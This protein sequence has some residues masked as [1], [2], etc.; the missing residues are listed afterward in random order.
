M[1]TP[2]VLKFGGATLGR[3]DRVRKTVGMVR[4]TTAPRVVVVSAREGVTDRLKK[5]LLLAEG[6]KQ[7]PTLN[8]VLAELHPGIP[9]VLQKNLSALT[10]DLR[11]AAAS[12]KVSPSQGDAVL[13]R[14]ER[15]SAHWYAARLTEVG[16]PAEALEADL[17]G[18]ETDGN[19]GGAIIRPLPARGPVRNAIRSVLRKGRVPVITGYI[20]RGTRGKV[21]TL[22]RG[23]SDYTATS[24][25]CLIGARRT[26]LVKTDVSLFTADPKL[27]RR[28]EPVR[29]LSYEEAEE[30][31]QF[32]AKVL[33]PLTVEPARQ[34]GMEV[35]V[36]SL[37]FPGLSTTI[38]PAIA[39][40]GIRAM[41]LLSPVA[42]LLLRVP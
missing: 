23:G 21:A 35:A 32:G 14:G 38:G 13:A 9:E 17:M 33:H 4:E 25:G 40:V 6:G 10:G 1:P 7:D 20:G 28:A 42:L 3:E 12:R 8:A 19:V 26:V 34:C 41:T 18:L 5:A 37:D 36:E 2:L 24:V 30:L 27:I 22:G 31:A 16:L 15:L 11:R 29:R 39:N